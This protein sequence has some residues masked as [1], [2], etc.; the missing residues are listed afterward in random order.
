MSYGVRYSNA[1]AGALID[2]VCKQAVAFIMNELF[3][4][5]NRRLFD[6]LLK[7]RVHMVAVTLNTNGLRTSAN[8]GHIV[9]LG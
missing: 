2:R 9:I 4:I 8:H 1:T 3:S 7:H 5:L 6:T